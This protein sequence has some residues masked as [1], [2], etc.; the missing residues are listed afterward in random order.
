MVKKIAFPA[1]LISVAAFI[2]LITHALLFASSTTTQAAAV[3]P[4]EVVAVVD[5]ECTK[6]IWPDIPQRCLE[7]VKAR[8][9][10]SAIAMTSQ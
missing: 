2:A 8:S 4:V 3:Q 7:R 9:S 5:D 6:A 10:I 1:L